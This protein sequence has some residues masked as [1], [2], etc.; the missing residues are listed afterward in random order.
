MKPKKKFRFKSQFKKRLGKKKKVEKTKEP[1][2]VEDE[3]SN[4]SFI[5]GLEGLENETRVLKGGEDFHDIFKLEKLK[6]CTVELQGNLQTAYL[7]DIENC[8]ISFSGVKTSVFI[9]SCHKS[10]VQ[11]MA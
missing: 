8:K 4:L 7:L 6:N 9:T 3:N 1:E 11:I 10:E 2:Q 5:Q